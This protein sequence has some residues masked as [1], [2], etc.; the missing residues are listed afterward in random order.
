M[1]L[2]IMK[3]SRNILFSGCKGEF[4]GSIRFTQD[5]RN[6]AQFLVLPID[7]EI[8]N[9]F[10]KHNFDFLLSK[11]SA[12]AHP[13]SMTKWKANKW[14]YIFFLAVASYEPFRSEFR[15]IFDEFL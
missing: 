6:V 11:S 4:E 12:N 5:T 2:N 8:L 15:G 10:A 9:H 13:G 1:N 7:L 3:K 14:M